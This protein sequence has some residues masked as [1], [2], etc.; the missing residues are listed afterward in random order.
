ML[1]KAGAICDRKDDLERT[2]LFH[3]VDLYH[4]EIARLLIAHNADP[5]NFGL[6]KAVSVSEMLPIRRTLLHILEERNGDA[7]RG[8][9]EILKSYT[10]QWNA[11]KI[12]VGN[13]P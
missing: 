8:M 10:E 12:C 4:Y 2:A 11:S 7:D 1:L 6:S 3:A 5:T 13:E 9:F